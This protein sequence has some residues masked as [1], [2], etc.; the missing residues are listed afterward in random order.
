LLQISSCSL[1]AFDRFEQRLEITFAKAFRTLA[2]NDLEKQ[3]R[4]V[5]HRF[6]E[7]LQQITFIVAIDKDA[8]P[9]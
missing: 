8:K 6:G 3:S 4:P 9:L 5:F 2:L 1:F 7:N